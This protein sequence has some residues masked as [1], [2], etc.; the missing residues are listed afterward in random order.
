L[1]QPPLFRSNLE[2]NR[3]FALSFIVSVPAG[4]L[5]YIISQY[6]MKPYIG[7]SFG[8]VVLSDFIGE[9]F[10]AFCML[11]VA[12]FLW[13]VVPNRR[14]GAALG[15]LAGLGFGLGYQGLSCVIG[16][17]D[18]GQAIMVM[19][20][21]TLMD[22]ISATFTG[23]GLFALISNRQRLNSF[24]RAL[25]GLPL[26]FYFLAV[27]S[28]LVWNAFAFAVRPNVAAE[29]A[30]DIIIVVPLFAFILRDFLGGHFNFQDFL[31]PLAE[32][33]V[34]V[35]EPPPPPPP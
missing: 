29:W 33:C 7:Y 9:T 22:V 19:I 27:I 26:F 13:L 31:R 14:Y 4:L 18:A 20:F 16:Q 1:E 34:L 17:P 11:F 3:G 6:G 21:L 12:V 32:P 35:P 10:K 28:W 30:L 24:F 25:I 23:L 15:A 5:A 2:P 8:S